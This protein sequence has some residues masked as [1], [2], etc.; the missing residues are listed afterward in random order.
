MH[1]GLCD[2]GCPV[3]ARNTLDFNYLAVAKQKGARVLPLHLV[4]DI[5]ASAGDYEVIAD[6]I[7]GGALHPKTFTA[8]R[9]IVAAGSIGI[10]RAAAARAR[11]RRPGRTSA[12]ASASAG[13]ATATSS[14]RPFTRSAR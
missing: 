14:R 11:Q 13:A 10:D 8:P 6:E 7:A 4:R 1:L 3:K 9:V 5:R 12:R 2:V